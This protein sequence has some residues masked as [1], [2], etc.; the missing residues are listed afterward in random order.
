MNLDQNIIYTVG[1][2][3]HPIA[4]FIALLR[5]HG[6]AAI[7][8]VR[9]SPYSRRNSQYNRETLREVLNDAG[10]GYVFLG[11]ELGARSEDPTCYRDEKVDYDLLAETSLFRDGLLRLKSEQEKHRIALMCAEKEPLH[12]HRTILVARK[13]IEGG[14]SVLHILADGSLETH[15]HVLLRLLDKLNIPVDDLFRSREEAINEAYRIQGEEIAYS[16][17]NEG[18]LEPSSGLSQDSEASG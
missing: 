6:I 1:H 11:E 17:R 16:I 3:T 12:C 18:D 2:S 13:L 5:Q 8:D 10:I 15:D 7:A 4:H 9:S 14:M